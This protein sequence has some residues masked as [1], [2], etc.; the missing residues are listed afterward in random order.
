M[1]ATRGPCADQPLPERSKKDEIIG[2][3]RINRALQAFSLYIEPRLEAGVRS[4]R[5]G[6]ATSVFAHPLGRISR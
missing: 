1:T 3:R 2:S 4:L 5:S 6:V